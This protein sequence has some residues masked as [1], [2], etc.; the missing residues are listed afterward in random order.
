MAF[1]Q[2]EQEIIKWG[3]QNGKTKDEVSRAI[4]NYRSGI[5][6]AKQEEE[7]TTKPSYLERVGKSYMEGGEAI[8]GAV[9]EAVSGKDIAPVAGVK[10]GLRTAGEI[11]KQAFTPITE[12]IAPTMQRGIEKVS[13][14]S[15]VQKIASS[16]PVGKALDTIQGLIQKHPESS[17]A[18]QDIFNIITLAIPAKAGKSV[19]T[20]TEI[21]KSKIGKVVEDLSPLQ[22]GEK[23]LEDIKLN[24]TSKNVEPRVQQS[25]ERLGEISSQAKPKTKI[26]SSTYDEFYKQEQKFKTNIKE[27][28]ALGI[29]GERTGNAFDA[30]V[31]QR[32]AM[33]KKM[34]EELKKV[35]DMPTDTSDAFGN[36]RNNLQESGV[37]YDALEG[38]IKPTT[39]ETKFTTEDLGLLENYAKS[40]QGLGKNPTLSNLDAF[41]SRI[42]SELNVYKTKNSIIGTTNAERIIKNSLSELRQSIEIDNPALKPYLDARKAYSELSDFLEEGQSFLGKKTQTG[43]YAKDASLTKSAVQS[44]LNQGK[45]DWLVKLEGLT[46]YPALDE[47]VLAL[48]AMKDSGNFRGLSLLETLAQGGVPTTKG[49][50]TQKIIDYILEKGAKAFTGTPEQQTKTFLQSLERK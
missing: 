3:L 8:K 31:A 42:P 15:M 48:Q 11:A 25:A 41:L 27:D 12:A 37:V 10:L 32:S 1:N 5:I 38:K 17:Q 7:I 16:E 34:G 45:K 18:L 47:T 23:L 22:S 4:T 19:K 35:G 14:S 46:G 20:G 30:V 43:D 40:I 21:I 13:E 44:I 36:F 6:P 2:K 33:G 26:P 49:N 24:L 9:S 28:T 50:I 29:V 39:A